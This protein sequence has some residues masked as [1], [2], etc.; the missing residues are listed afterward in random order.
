MNSIGP[1]SAQG[2]MMVHDPRAQNGPTDP[3]HRHRV[4]ASTSGHRAPG[5]HG[6]SVGQG[7]GGG[8]ASE[9]RGIERRW[10]G[11]LA[12][13][14]QHGSATL[15]AAARTGEADAAVGATWTAPAAR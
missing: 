9:R 12:P 13:W 2:L 3:F 15:S 14:R 4:G 10:R 7:R 6:E 1:L 8:G 11:G 5:S